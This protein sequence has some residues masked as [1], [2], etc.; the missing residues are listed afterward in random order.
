MAW[1]RA[2]V[3]KWR[4]ILHILD[5]QFGRTIK[6]IYKIFFLFWNMGEN[7]SDLLMVSRKHQSRFDVNV[8]KTLPE[9]S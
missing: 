6:S 8:Q 1:D 4:V 7:K 5:E 2:V 3:K 9:K